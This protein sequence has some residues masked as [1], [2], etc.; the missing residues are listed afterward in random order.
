M[1]ETDT[2]A[3][4][5]PRHP[6][7]DWP[8]RL[9][10]VLL[11]ASILSSWLSYEWG[12]MTWHFYS[13]YVVM[14]LIVFR[15]LWGFV[16]SR[17][18]RFSDFVPGFPTLLRYLRSGVSPTPG[19]NP[20]GALSVLALL[21]L[22]TLQVTTGILNVDEEGNRGLY[23]VLVPADWTDRVGALHETLFNVLCGL[24]ML[25]I[26]AVIFHT[27]KHEPRMMS[28]MLTGHKDTPATAP[29]VS[30]LRAVFVLLVSVA[31]VTAVI[32]NAPPPPAAPV[33]Y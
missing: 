5:P 13:G 24:I 32:V 18:S 27:R 28:G 1:D 10:H 15:L 9:F 33:Y 25:H 17:H 19:H 3:V 12:R 30:L 22:L 6:V 29:P 4:Q 11:I 14:T 21:G 23:S 2:P 7:W 26:V 31:V 16:G 8:T 20:L